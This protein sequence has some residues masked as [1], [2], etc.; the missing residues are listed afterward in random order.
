MRALAG[1]LSRTLLP[2]RCLVC[3][4][5]GGQGRDLCADCARGLPWNAPACARCG[6]PLPEPAPA[7]GRCLHQPPPFD[8]CTAVFRYEPPVDRLLQRLKYGGD[9]AAGALLAALMRERLAACCDSGARDP[10][11][12]AHAPADALVPVPLHPGRLGARGYNQA[13]ELARPLA[14]AFAVPLRADLLARTRRTAAQTELDA[15]ARR[16]NVR[17]AFVATAAVPGR[18]VLVDD[19]MTTG[20]TLAACASALRAAGARQVTLWVAARAP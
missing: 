20:A 15:D 5:A 16:A 7:C 3:A 4:A 14:R 13:L 8:A 12:T 9:L 2:P 19:T 17:G 6:L 18:V 11:A 1:R 10:I